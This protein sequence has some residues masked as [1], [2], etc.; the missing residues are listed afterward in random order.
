MGI[1]CYEYYYEM[2]S[3][4][5]R[6]VYRDMYEAFVNRATSFCIPNCEYK[7]IGEIFERLTDDHPEIFYVKYI[8]IQSRSFIS[9]YRIV[10]QY[11][12]SKDEIQYL[13]DAVDDSI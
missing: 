8:Q 1:S 5:E 7:K 2:M 9:G 11:R 13:R 10:P 4:S 3:S 12:F 6:A